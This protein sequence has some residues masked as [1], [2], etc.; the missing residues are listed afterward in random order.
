MEW[1]EELTI[2][3]MKYFDNIEAWIQ[4]KPGIKGFFTGKQKKN[5]KKKQK[6]EADRRINKEEKNNVKENTNMVR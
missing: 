4:I 6:L 1:V 2:T 5:V 3:G